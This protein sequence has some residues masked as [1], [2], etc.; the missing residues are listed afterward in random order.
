MLVRIQNIL[1]IDAPKTYFSNSEVAGTNVIRWKNPNAFQPSWAIQLGETQI[2]QSE[3]VVLGTASPSGTAG[4]LT[5]NTLYEHPVDTPIYG[6]KYNQVVFE[7]ST[8]GTTGTASPLTG[9]TVTL[10]PNSQYTVFDDTTGISTYGYRAYFQNSVTAGTSAESDWLTPQGFSF[11]SL[12]KIRQ[13]VKNRFYNSSFIPNDL[14]IDDWVNEWVTQMNNVMIDVNEDYGLGTVGIGFSGTTEL[15]TI[16]A[17][18]FKGGF[19]RVWYT[20]GS[21]TYQATSMDSASFSPNRAFTNTYPYYYMQG[22]T[23]IGRKPND[24]SGSFIVE[25]FKATPLLVEDTDIIP[26]PMQ[27]H[28]KSFVDYAHAQGLRRDNKYQEAEL[29]E[30]KAIQGL[31]IFRIAITPRNRSNTKYVDIVEDTGSDFSGGIW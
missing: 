13:R 2:P 6:I 4:T 29:M 3:V 12:G 22:D 30:A 1:P 9:G 10:Q 27:E 19:K 25:Y 7:R 8:A 24:Q 15:G 28:T 26:T 5:A 21:G 23:V 17:T 20:D 14:V 11:Y 16:T 31:G 18:D